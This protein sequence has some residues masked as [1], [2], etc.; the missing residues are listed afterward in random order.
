MLKKGC[1]AWITIVSEEETNEVDI[2]RV[3]IVNELEVFPEELLGL[4]PDQEVEFTI[5]LL[6]N[7]EPISI[8]LY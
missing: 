5:D 4:T 3:L 7:I 6:L 2:H 1:V 8:P